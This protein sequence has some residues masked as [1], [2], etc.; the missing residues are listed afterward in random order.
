MNAEQLVIQSRR[1]FAHA[2]RHAIQDRAAG[3]YAEAVR[4]SMIRE[5]AEDNADATS[6]ERIALRAAERSAWRKDRRN[7]IKQN[8][9]RWCVRHDVICYGAGTIPF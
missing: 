5:N 7:Q 6:A 4:V 9:R 8:G 3:G 1:A 2:V